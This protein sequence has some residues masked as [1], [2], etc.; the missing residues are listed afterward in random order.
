LQ[1][2]DWSTHS[3]ILS[4]LS[5]SLFALPFNFITIITIIY[6]CMLLLL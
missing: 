4:S 2:I 3:L 6:V 1:F 5:L